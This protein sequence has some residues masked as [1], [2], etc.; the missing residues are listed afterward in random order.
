MEQVFNEED[1]YKDEGWPPESLKY[2]SYCFFTSNE[3]KE[4]I[5]YDQ[6]ALV[7]NALYPYVR[8]TK[9]RGGFQSPCG[10]GTIVPTSSSFAR[11][12]DEERDEE[13]P[14]II[15]GFAAIYLSELKYDCNQDDYV[16]KINRNQIINNFYNKYLDLYFQSHNGIRFSK[17]SNEKKELDFIAGHEII[18]RGLWEKS[19]P[20]KKYSLLYEYASDAETDYERF[21]QN[22]KAELIK[23]IEKSLK[24]HVDTKS[25]QIGT[26]IQNGDKSVFINENYGSVT[27]K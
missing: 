9:K 13:C 4:C 22:R 6:F 7:N 18:I 15:W 3:T 1:F 10:L 20:L 23:K 5:D 8:L 21:L 19:Y 14:K 11:K 16:E 12:S 24:P 2:F 26:T 17:I 25:D 27:I